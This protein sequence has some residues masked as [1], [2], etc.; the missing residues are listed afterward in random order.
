MAKDMRKTG[1]G[2]ENDVERGALTVR[3]AVYRGSLRS[4][5]LGIIRSTEV[6]FYRD[7]NMLVDFQCGKIQLLFATAGT[8]GIIAVAVRIAQQRP[9]NGQH[10]NYIHNVHLTHVPRQILIAQ[11]GRHEAIKLRQ[12]CSS[13]DKYP[14]AKYSQQRRFL[15]PGDR[16]ISAK[17]PASA[18]IPR[19]CEISFQCRAIEPGMYVPCSL[20]STHL[21]PLTRSALISGVSAASSS[22]VIKRRLVLQGLTSTEDDAIDS[23]HQDLETFRRV[24]SLAPLHAGEYQNQTR[25]HISYIRRTM[26]DTPTAY[27]THV[28]TRNRRSHGVSSSPIDANSIK[29]SRREMIDDCGVSG[30]KSKNGRPYSSRM[31]TFRNRCSSRGFGL[32]PVASFTRLPNSSRGRLANS[33]HRGTADAARVKYG[34]HPDARR[35]RRSPEDEVSNALVH[36]SNEVVSSERVG[37]QAIDR[38][39]RGLSAAPHQL[40]ARALDRSRKAHCSPSP[41]SHL[42]DAVSVYSQA[43]GRDLV[44][45]Y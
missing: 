19:Y 41:P 16:P 44:S 7:H 35:W 20:T 6:F 33:E 17:W 36:S 12:D 9:Q 29:Q 27:S 8:A 1:T 26:I 13:N 32:F 28:S 31:K 45:K 38:R 14:E 4:L 23:D 24:R 42:P 39:D 40:A 21:E 10:C 37:A 22:G 5:H 11:Q 2:N 3:S 18:E 15:K 43:I 25:C 30:A 34:N